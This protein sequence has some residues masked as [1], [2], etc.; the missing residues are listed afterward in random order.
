MVSGVDP[1]FNALR[2]MPPPELQYPDFH[3][4]DFFEKIGCP[5]L[6]HKY[7]QPEEEAEAENTALK[8]VERASQDL[9]KIMFE[10]VT[11]KHTEKKTD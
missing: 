1:A 6:K 10:R 5:H 3:D 4:D 8:P 2:V 11:Q 7:C 9:K